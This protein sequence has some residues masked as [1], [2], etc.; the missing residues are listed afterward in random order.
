MSFA[1]PPKPAARDAEVQALAARV[2]QLEDEAEAARHQ[3]QVQPVYQSIPP[4]PDAQYAGDWAP[5]PVQYASPP[6]QYGYNDAPPAYSGCDPGWMNCGLGWGP[7]IYPANIVVLRTPGFR[8][9]HPIRVE[10][11]QPAIHPMRPPAGA[12]RPPG[13][14]TRPPAAVHRG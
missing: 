3:A 4:P 11:H 2:R 12:M 7:G 13:A 8:R 9:F 6:V 14:A 10:H 5:P 1:T